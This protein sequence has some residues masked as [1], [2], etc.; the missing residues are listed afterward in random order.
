MTRVI[1]AAM[2]LVRFATREALCYVVLFEV[3]YSVVNCY[4]KYK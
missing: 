2:S 3:M 1:S 4:G